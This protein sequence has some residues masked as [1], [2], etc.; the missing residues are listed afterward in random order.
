M[1]LPKL[2]WLILSARPQCG[3][4]GVICETRGGRY[5]SLW[6]KLDP[7]HEKLLAKAYPAEFAGA[8]Y[9]VTWRGDQQEAIYED[10]EDRRTYLEILA[11][12]L[13]R[14]HWFYYAYCLIG[15]HYHLV[16]E[17]LEGNPQRSRVPCKWGSG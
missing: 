13:E 4:R 14:F 7:W 6:S 15:N 5:K 1:E 11:E 9:H 2:L 12:V 17:T 10:E 3:L 16:I 8:L